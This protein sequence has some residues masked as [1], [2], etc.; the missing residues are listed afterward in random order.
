M[1]DANLKILEKKVFHGAIQKLHHLDDLIKDRLYYELNTI[2][3]LNIAE[4]FLICSKIIDICNKN[5]YLRSFGRGSA[6]GSLVNYCLDITKINPLQY[7]LVFQRFLNP[8]VSTNVNIVID[9]PEGRRQDII[10]ELAIELSDYEIAELL[11]HPDADIDRTFKLAKFNNTEYS[12]HPCCTIISKCFNDIE[13]EQTKINDRYYFVVDN[14]KEQ[15]NK[16]DRSRFDILEFEYLKRLEEIS[17]RL[18]NKCHPYNINLNDPDVFE[19]FCSGETTNIFQYNTISVIK[20]LKDFQPSTIHDLSIINALFRPWGMEY[21]PKI[22]HN[23]LNGYNSTF[24]RDERVNELLKETYG[25]IVYQETFMHLANKIAGMEMNLADT[26]RR[27]LKENKDVAKIKQFTKEFKKGCLNNSNLSVLE[28]NKLTNMVLKSI[29]YAFIKSHSL[30]YSIIGYWG[31]YYKE[32]FREC[33]DKVFKD[34]YV[35]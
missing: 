31:A 33:F 29:P 18:G 6:P 19:L 15:V 3:E 28:I 1:V 23:K 11:Y 27:F 20:I 26:Y 25:I 32:H 34:I 14:Y 8:Q 21:L 2:K 24:F 7:D 30:S 13:L 5:G 10:E 22:M 4:Y 12:I 17:R 35:I 9:I 16:I